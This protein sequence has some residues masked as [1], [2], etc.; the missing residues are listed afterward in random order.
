M[1]DG[2]CPDCGQELGSNPNCPRC[3]AYKE[4]LDERWEKLQRE[5]KEVDKKKAEDTLQKAENWKSSFWAKFAPQKILR[6]VALFGKVIYD[7]VKGVENEEGVRCPVP[8]HTVAL[9]VVTLA[10]IISPFDLIPDFIPVLGW[11]DD[12]TLGMLTLAA[13]REDVRR[14]CVWRGLDPVHYGVCEGD[15]CATGGCGFCGAE[16]EQK[17][18]KKCLNCV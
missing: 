13:I 6:M 18:G 4:K 17:F 11:L 12:L 15:A 9:S 16:A 10:Y 14:Y 1:K 3:R 5:A 2:I 7:G 8:W